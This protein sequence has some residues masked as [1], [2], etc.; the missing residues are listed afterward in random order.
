LRAQQKE[1]A[2]LDAPPLLIN[3]QDKDEEFEGRFDCFEACLAQLPTAKRNLIL[4]YYEGDK[5][6]KIVNR[7]K[8]AEEAGMPIGRLRIQAHRIREKLEICIENCLSSKASND[9]S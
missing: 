2:L 3:D 1:K 4:K 7:Q 5:E 9:A 6:T 8:L